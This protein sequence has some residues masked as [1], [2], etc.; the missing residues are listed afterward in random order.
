[1]ENETKNTIHPLLAGASIVIIVA[2]LRAA[3]SNRGQK[4]DTG[5][6]GEQVRG[7]FLRL[8]DAGDGIAL[9]TTDAGG[10]SLPQHS[11]YRSHQLR[12]GERPSAEFLVR[13]GGGCVD[14][15]RLFLDLRSRTPRPRCVL[16][17]S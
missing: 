15:A 8:M 11:R 6:P 9:H 10:W 7:P 16:V 12:V 17:F 4:A 13:S 1:M 5:D 2:G 14:S 3:A